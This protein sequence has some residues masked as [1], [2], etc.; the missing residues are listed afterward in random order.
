MVLQSQNIVEYIEK[1]ENSFS[2]K[3][4]SSYVFALL[5]QYAESLIFLF[6]SK[7]VRRHQVFI[8]LYQ[9]KKIRWHISISEYATGF[10]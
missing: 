10:L 4:I 9:G 2:F 8:A 7:V 6:F 5:N 3:K 1:I